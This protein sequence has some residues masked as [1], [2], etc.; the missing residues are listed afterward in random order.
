MRSNKDF[1]IELV[2]KYP[3]E[4]RPKARIQ[5]AWEHWKIMRTDE[6]RLAVKHLDVY[7]KL[8]SYV[9]IQYT[10]WIDSYLRNRAFDLD[11]LYEL[12]E[13]LK[14]WNLI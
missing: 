3:E 8:K 1:F 9:D 2:K 5:T 14:S 4:R 6:Q 11:Y 10:H 7:L 12:Q 13:Q